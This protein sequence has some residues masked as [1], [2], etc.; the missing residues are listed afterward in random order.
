MPILN[1]QT[2]EFISHSVEQTERFGVRLGGLL[3]MGDVVC[4]SG[5][6]GA[7]KTALAR[8]VALG[9]GSLYRVTSPTFTLINEY[10]REKDGRILYH[11][12]SYRL[13]SEDDVM[14][15]GVEDILL[16]G[17]TVMIEWPEQL[18]T[19]LPADRLWITFDPFEET[20]RRIRFEAHGKRPFSLMTQFQ[21]NTFG[22]NK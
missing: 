8:G 19:F 15:T 17:E 22:K 1:Q 12:D 7:G 2:I 10:P 9:W 6:L 13:E 3:Q 21:K 16:D 5:E 4:L 20:K 18:K 11:M 14:T